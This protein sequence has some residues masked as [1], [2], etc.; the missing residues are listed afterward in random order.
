MHNTIFRM[1]EHINDWNN[2]NNNNKSK[3]K[4]KNNSKINKVIDWII[5]KS[6][7]FYIS[8][9]NRGLFKTK[10]KANRKSSLTSSTYTNKHG[11]RDK[12]I[13]YKKFSYLIL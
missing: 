2:K 8:I 4:N 6:I 7:E 1:N 11:I 3:N 12:K 13:I 10:Q 9:D 5:K